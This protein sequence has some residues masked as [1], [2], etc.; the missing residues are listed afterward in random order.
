M[1]EV[2]NMIID[3]A[4]M[5]LGGLVMLAYAVANILVVANYSIRFYVARILGRAKMV[6]QN[7]CQCLLSTCLGN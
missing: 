2:K 4:L 6:W 5:I 1:K 3:Y 7:L